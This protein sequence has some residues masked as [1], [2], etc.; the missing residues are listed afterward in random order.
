MARLEQ[1]LEAKK[2]DL[3]GEVF[4]LMVSLGDFLE[5][6]DLM[7]SFKKSKQPVSSSSSSTQQE[8]KTSGLT[9]GGSSG[10]GG[11][12]SSGGSGGGLDLCITGKKV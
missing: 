7:L 1:V 11:G 12:F 10:K 5:F 8:S 6:K 4:D 3:S 2:D 9:V